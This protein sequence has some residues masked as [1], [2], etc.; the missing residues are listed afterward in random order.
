M[1][2]KLFHKQIFPNRSSFNLAIAVFAFN[3]IVLCLFVLLNTVFGLENPL[4]R[5]AGTGTLEDARGVLMLCG[6]W[7]IGNCLLLLGLVDAMKPASE[8]KQ[9]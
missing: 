7:A 4:T 1:F 5:K 9:S 6:F 8:K 2:E 3:L